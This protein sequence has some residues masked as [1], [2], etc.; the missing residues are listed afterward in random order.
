MVGNP[1]YEGKTIEDRRIEVIAHVPALKK[2]D[3]EMVKSEER[4]KAGGGK[5]DAATPA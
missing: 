3:G 5:T 4:E 2:L 1:L